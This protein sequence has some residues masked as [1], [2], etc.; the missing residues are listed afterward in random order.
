MPQNSFFRTLIYAKDE[1][2]L[3]PPLNPE[4]QL[5]EPVTNI[6]Q[7]ISAEARGMYTQTAAVGQAYYL[8]MVW[9]GHWQ[10]SRS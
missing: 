7:V 3:S 4:P 6:G 5:A 2:K 1:M 8:P 9:R 10:R